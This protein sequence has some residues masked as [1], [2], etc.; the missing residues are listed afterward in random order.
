MKS[1]PGRGF[2]DVINSGLR[3][4]CRPGWVRRKSRAAADRADPG[5]QARLAATPARLSTQGGKERACRPPAERRPAAGIS[6]FRATVNTHVSREEIAGLLVE[7]E[8]EAQGASTGPLS[9]SEAPAEPSS[10]EDAARTYLRRMGEGPRL[11]P[12]EEVYY[13]KQYATARDEVRRTLGNVAPVALKALERV[14]GLENMR[15]LMRFVDVPDTSEQAGLAT[16]LQGAAEA[17]RRLLERL[18]EA[19]ELPGEDGRETRDLIRDSIGEVLAA[20]PLRESVFSECVASVADYCGEARRLQTQMEGAAKV[21]TRGAVEERL[22]EIERALLCP[23]EALEGVNDELGRKQAAQKEAKHIMVE[24]N[25]RLVVSIAKRFLN[26]GLPFLDLVQEG[27]IGLVR[28]V[29]KFQYQRGHRF[30]TYATYWIRQA[31]SRALAIHGRTIRIPANM[32]AL[33]NRIRATEERLL[34]QQ[35]R[36]PAPAEVAAELDLPVAKVR[37]LKKMSK[38]LIS[39][40]STVGA[41]GEGQL[42]DFIRDRTEHSPDETAAMKILREAVFSALDTLAEREREVLVLHFG[43]GQSDAMTLEQISHRF[44]LT[45]ERIRQI[46][47]G[48]LRKLRHPTRRRFFDGYG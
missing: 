11:T 48:A 32:V 12:E 14:L 17:V 2:R 44:G 43:L 20:L 24:G 46:E 35:G 36:E 21:E 26:C 16:Q 3:R 28:A 42:G 6:S 18:E 1:A 27:N 10:F 41:D 37:A 38:Q 4:R 23:V 45:R 5:P 9:G 8:Q 30:S 22:A 40:H 39:L 7:D 25:L 15:E 19:G 31:I 34:Q 13:A 47:L 29:E 33:L